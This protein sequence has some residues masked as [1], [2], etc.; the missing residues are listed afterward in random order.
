MTLS[1]R[2]LTH[3]C[4]VGVQS[5][6]TLGEFATGLAFGQ[7]RRMLWAMMSNG[8][9]GSLM[10]LLMPLAILALLFRDKGPVGKFIKAGAISPETARKPR[11]LE[12][13]NPDLYSGAI[14]RGVLVAT[15]DGRYWVDLGALRRSRR[16]VIVAAISLFVVVGAAVVYFAEWP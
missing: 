1:G 3:V 9:P 4:T 12:I 10:V 15:G 5:V 16:R 7:L 6:K 14:R 2:I 13:T 11:S 8:G